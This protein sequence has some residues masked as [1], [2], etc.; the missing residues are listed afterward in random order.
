VTGDDPAPFSHRSQ[1]TLA[2]IGHQVAVAD[3]MGWRFSGRLAWL[4]WRAVY[5][6]KLPGLAQQ[7]RVA[8]GW[9]TD[10][11]FPRDLVRTIDTGPPDVRGDR[12]AGR[13]GPSTDAAPGDEAPAGGDA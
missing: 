7:V 11:F 8:L 4:L 12:A 2:V 6:V 9:A 5:L 10:L 13:P 3:V 1:G